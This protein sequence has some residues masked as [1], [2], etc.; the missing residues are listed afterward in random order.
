MIQLQHELRRELISSGGFVHST[1]AFYAEMVILAKKISENVGA[2]QLGT[3]PLIYE[4]W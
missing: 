3:T 4:S 1:L 2:K